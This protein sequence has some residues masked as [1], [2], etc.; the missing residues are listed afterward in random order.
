MYLEKPK[1]NKFENKA[2]EGFSLGYSDN[3][4]SYLITFFDRAELITRS[5]CN[6]KFNVTSFPGKTHVAN[7]ENDSDI[8]VKL[9]ERG[10]EIEMQN[11]E[12]VADTNFMR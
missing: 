1:R 7:I 11:T 6:A 9:K 12:S 5:S 8:F 2:L 10:S 3:S 4:K